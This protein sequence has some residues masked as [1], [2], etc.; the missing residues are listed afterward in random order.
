MDVFLNCIGYLIS[1]DC[2]QGT[3]LTSQKQIISQHMLDY[4]IITDEGI[5][6][7]RWQTKFHN[8]IR[9]KFFNSK[10]DL[11]EHIDKIHRITDEKI[12][13]AIT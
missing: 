3:P 6:E 8:A 11:K 4:D 12:V 7:E 2:T 9:G 1:I 5:A 10:R 13:A